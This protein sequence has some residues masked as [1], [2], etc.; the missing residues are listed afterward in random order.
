[1][2]SAEQ[3]EL[4][5]CTG[6]DTPAG[7]L[8]RR[9]W[10][11][12]CLVEELQGERPVKAVQLLGEHLVVFRDDEGRFGLVGRQCPHRGVDLSYGRLEDGGLRCPFHGWL[13][14]VTGRCLEQPAEPQG[15]A[16]HTKIRHTAYPCQER[17]GIV[18]AYLGSGTAPEFPQFDC[19]A[20]PGTHTFAFKGHIDCNWLQALE[21]GIDPAHAS[22]LHRFFEDDDPGA[23]YGQ[24]FRDKTL[25]ADTPMTRILREFTVPEIT[26]EETDYGLRLISLRRI[27]DADMHVRITNLMFP[28]AI[29]IP[30]STEMVLTQWHVPINDEECYWYSIF[31]SYGEAVD[32]ATMREQRLELYT[33]PDYKPRLN[34]SN[35]WG[36]DARQQREQTYTGMGSDINVHDNWAVE[37]PGRIF[38]RTKE[39]LGTTDKAITMNRRILI[40]AIKAASEGAPLPGLPGRDEAKALRGPVAIDTIGPADDW[41]SCWQARDR[42]RRSGSQWARALI[43]A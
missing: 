36:F 10:Q 18:F 30:L 19:F 6:P 33:L 24:Q 4:V 37:S 25:G 32:K 11:P 27:S 7:A 21:V 16:F 5:T 23:G 15:S 22:F 3:N 13:F 14:D 12:A 41:Q 38:D 43:D 8:M 28:Q 39:H 31:A 29:V 17:N 20:A 34:R 42:E 40:R 26:V 35:N 9:Y 2:L 1:M